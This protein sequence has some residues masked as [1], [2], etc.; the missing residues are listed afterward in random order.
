[1]TAIKKTRLFVLAASGLLVGSAAHAFGPEDFGTNFISP[2]EARPVF[3]RFSIPGFQ[4]SVAR[5]TDYDNV[6]DGIVNIKNMTQAIIPIGFGQFQIRVEQTFTTVTPVP[7]QPG[8]VDVTT[9]SILYVIPSTENGRPIPGGPSQV[10]RTP[11][12]SQT[13][14]DFA[15][16]NLPTSTEYFPIREELGPA[17]VPSP[18]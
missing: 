15:D 8:V 12:S 9:E 13:G 2:S 16:L 3:S 5:I 18:P 7:G 17:F 14:V 1:M 10:I 6:D 11:P 4:V